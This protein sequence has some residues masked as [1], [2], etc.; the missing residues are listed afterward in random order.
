MPFQLSI[1]SSLPLLLL[2]PFCH[3]FV[4]KPMVRSNFFGEYKQMELV[5]IVYLPICAL[6]WNYFLLEVFNWMSIVI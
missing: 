5:N 3:H 6:L 4:H 2:R 1:F